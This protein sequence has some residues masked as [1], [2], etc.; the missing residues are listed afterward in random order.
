MPKHSRFAFAY[1]RAYSAA[2]WCSFEA[3]PDRCLI[4]S[5]SKTRPRCPSEP[6]RMALQVH[7]EIA[8][9]ELPASPPASDANRTLTYSTIAVMLATLLSMVLGFGRE[10]VNARYFGEQWELDSFLVAAIIPTLVFGVFNGALVSALVPV[11]SAY[12]AADDTEEVWRLSSTVINVLFI[13]LSVCAVVGWLA[14]PYLD[15][16]ST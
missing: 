13:V 8:A 2:S 9:A 16:K 5:T 4:T 3:T 11:F 14:A 6:S 7:Q 12:F 10:M 1:E 15:R